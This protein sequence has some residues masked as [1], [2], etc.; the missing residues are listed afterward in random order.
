MG[1]NRKYKFEEEEMLR[2][3]PDVRFVDAYRR[4]KRIKGFYVHLVVYVLANA[5]FIAI[6]FNQSWSDSKVFWSWSTFSTALFWGIG[7]A[8]HGLSVFG[9]DIFFGKHWEERKIQQFMKNDN[10]S[11]WE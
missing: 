6:N 2:N 4:M 8:A 5:L 7:L 9:R 1:R 3:N 10:Q 11:K